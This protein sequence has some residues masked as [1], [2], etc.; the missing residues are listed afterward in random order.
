[1]KVEKINMSQLLLFRMSVLFL[2][3]AGV[4]WRCWLVF[5][6][7]GL[8]FAVKH[9]KPSGTG[10]LLA[11]F[12]FLP[13]AHHFPRDLRTLCIHVVSALPDTMCNTEEE[14]SASGI[15]IKSLRCLGTPHSLRS[16]T[17]IV[18]TS[19]YPPTSDCFS[20]ASLASIPF[21][22]C[23][24]KV[25]LHPQLHRSSDSYH[26]FVILHVAWAFPFT[27]RT[28]APLCMGCPVVVKLG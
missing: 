20:L 1:M 19:R 21:P 2:P 22:T 14:V 23:S 8:D 27:L 28:S 9:M 3:W 25:C 10:L 16:D 6:P 13:A 7:F 18:T 11:S 4:H 26:F 12:A 5:L 24:L 17:A 15:R